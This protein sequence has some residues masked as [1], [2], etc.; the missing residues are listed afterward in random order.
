M[1]TAKA[2]TTQLNE[3][4][5][6]EEGTEE[7]KTHIRVSVCIS[8]SFLYCGSA[9][10]RRIRNK[11]PRQKREYTKAMGDKIH[12]CLS[13]PSSP[14][15]LSSFGRMDVY[16]I[17]V[18]A[19]P[20]YTYTQYLRSLYLH[21]I[22]LFLFLSLGNYTDESHQL[23]NVYANANEKRERAGALSIVIKL[24]MIVISLSSVSN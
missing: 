20:Y 9:V 5:E 12:C 14:S 1:A 7:K 21:I 18:K 11:S 22:S 3:E 16:T 17:T 6:E 8:E 4:E 10:Y 23:L 24:Y 19:T 2:H 15:L 13:P